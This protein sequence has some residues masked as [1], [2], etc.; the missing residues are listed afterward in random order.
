MSRETGSADRTALFRL[1]GTPLAHDDCPMAEA[2]AHRRER[3]AT[4]RSRSNGLTALARA[5]LVNI[6]PLKDHRGRIEGAINCFQD[7]S[8]RSRRWKS[9]LRSKGADLEDFF[10]NSAIGLHI[11]SGDG[12]ILRANKAELSLLGYR[13]DEYV[14]RHIAE[15]HAD[16]P[17]IGDI[18][19]RL[20]CGE[21]LDRYPG[22]S[23]GQGRFDQACADHVEQPLRRR[24]IR[25]YS[26]LYHRR[27]QSL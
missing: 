15:F 12:I 1:D 4:R 13:A 20:S 27:D 8:E 23:A 18:L 25:Q 10:E 21:K 19:N 5:V 3:F 16:T 7:I 11:V 26:L 17:V 2:V 14:G 6:R 24:E 9:K 22:P